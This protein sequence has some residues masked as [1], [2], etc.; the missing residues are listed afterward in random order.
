MKSKR[1][2]EILKKKTDFL[3]L[4]DIRR[5]DKFILPRS[6]RLVT[7]GAKERKNKDTLYRPTLVRVRVS[8]EMTDVPTNRHDRK[9]C[10]LIPPT[11]SK[12]KREM[13]EK[14]KQ[15]NKGKAQKGIT[16]TK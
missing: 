9:D 4:F 3:P 6:T 13:K 1:G 7:N 5:K 14:H 10:N 8:L 15:G 12:G 11:D 16:T 2:E